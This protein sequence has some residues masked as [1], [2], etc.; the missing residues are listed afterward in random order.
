MAEA[1]EEFPTMQVRQ[2]ADGDS[3]QIE[4]PGVDPTTAHAAE[5]SP[6]LRLGVGS[7]S[8]FF[9]SLMLTL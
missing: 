2:G 3:G 6:Q 7:G 5:H 4:E 8:C 9:K 1:G